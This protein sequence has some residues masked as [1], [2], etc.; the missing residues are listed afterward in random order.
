MTRQELAIQ[1]VA[2]RY[3]LILFNS[4]QGIAKLA[5]NSDGG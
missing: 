1:R 3:V 5:V 2:N 4:N